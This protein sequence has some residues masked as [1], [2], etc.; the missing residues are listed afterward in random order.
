MSKIFS[1]FIILLL[2]VI[3]ASA[4]DLKPTSWKSYGVTFSAPAD[5]I[6]EDDSEESLTISNSEISIN[7]QLLY[8]DGL[9]EKEL[10][11]DLKQISKEDNLEQTSEISTI[12]LIHFFGAYITGTCET[13]Q[14]LYSYLTTKD[15]ACSFFI[16][17]ICGKS[18]LSL[19]EE[20]LNSFKLE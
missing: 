6:V 7:I 19:A 3:S 11:E 14:C 12:E 17:I 10:I 1:I 20:I 9:K 15:N 18:N 4:K 16:S 8:G 13:D 5:I 2:S